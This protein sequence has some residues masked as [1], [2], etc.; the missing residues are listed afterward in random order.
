MRLRY[1]S[2]HI[3][4]GSAQRTNTE[5]TSGYSDNRDGNPR[6]GACELRRR[7]RT[8]TAPANYDGACE[9]RR[10]LRTT[11]APANCCE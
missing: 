2:L 1:G 8:T 7:L 6:D 10:R 4:V 11:T 9:L 5:R 3:F